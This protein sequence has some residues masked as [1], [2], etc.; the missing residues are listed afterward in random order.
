MAPSPPPVATHRDI[1]PVT[2]QG[3][4]RAAAAKALWGAANPHPLGAALDA[5][6]SARF[7]YPH[8]GPDFLDQ[9]RRRVS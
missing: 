3:W 7:A 8:D 2:R 5:V 1:G 6:D 9:V 4:R